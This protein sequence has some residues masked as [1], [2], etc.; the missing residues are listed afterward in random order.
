MRTQFK[1]PVLK[2]INI[3]DY[4]THRRHGLGRV[5]AIWGDQSVADVVFKKDGRPLFHS[6]HFSY[7]VKIELP[8]L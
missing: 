6:A 5:V 8:E 3:N 2:R 1:R 4:V 7:L